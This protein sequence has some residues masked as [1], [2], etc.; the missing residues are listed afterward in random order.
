LE[1]ALQL[2]PKNPDAW[3][4]VG[5]FLKRSGAPA[6]KRIP[7]HEQA[8]TQFANQADLKVFHQQ[9]LANIYQEM[10]G[11]SSLKKIEQ[12]ILSQ[13]R[14]KHS[15]LRVHMAASQL[16]T[17]LE[18]EIYRRRKKSSAEKSTLW[19]RRE[20]ATSIAILP[21]HTSAS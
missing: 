13:N 16:F 5:G 7:L 14:L 17:L 10:G 3:L 11:T 15:D 9:A 18:E 12:L 4:A 6:K 1:K 8:A 20:A 19:A 2:Y 21:S